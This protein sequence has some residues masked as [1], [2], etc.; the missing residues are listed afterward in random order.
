VCRTA[1][2]SAAL[3]GWHTDVLWRRH[4]GGSGG[5][6]EFE[7]AIQ[8]GRCDGRGSGGQVDGSEEGLNGCRLGEG[9]DDGDRWSL[10]VT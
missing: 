1:L 6:I 4:D 7:L 2:R 10:H 9:G 5:L 8:V 3:R